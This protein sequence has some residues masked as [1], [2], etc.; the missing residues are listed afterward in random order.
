MPKRDQAQTRRR[1]QTSA[2]YVSGVS[3]QRQPRSLG[4]RGTA[5]LHLLHLTSSSPDTM[6]PGF[7]K[8]KFTAEDQGRCVS[9]TPHVAHPLSVP[10][11]SGCHTHAHTLLVN[12]FSHFTHLQPPWISIR[13]VHIKIHQVHPEHTISWAQTG[14]PFFIHYKVSFWIAYEKKH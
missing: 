12:C 2:S 8:E 14:H 11:G 9:L 6:Q 4:G 5:L 1:I 3:G 7:V 13:E 10:G